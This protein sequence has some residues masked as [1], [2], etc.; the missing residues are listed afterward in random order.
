VGLPGLG[1]EMENGQ[2]P[3]CF[4]SDPDHFAGDGKAMVRVITRLLARGYGFLDGI[5]PA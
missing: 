2:F 5:L 1:G 3:R 4:Q